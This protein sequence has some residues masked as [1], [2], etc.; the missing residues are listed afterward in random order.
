MRWYEMLFQEFRGFLY[1]NH[2][3]L[4]HARTDWMHA[5]GYFSDGKREPLRDDHA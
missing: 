2:I 3:A 1:E 4:L 5:H